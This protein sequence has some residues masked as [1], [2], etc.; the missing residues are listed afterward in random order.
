MKGFCN[1]FSN[2]LVTWKP[3][4]GVFVVIL[5]TAGRYRDS[6]LLKMLYKSDSNLC[7]RLF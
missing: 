4:S 2:P 6:M 5:I 3:E 1:I 7:Y